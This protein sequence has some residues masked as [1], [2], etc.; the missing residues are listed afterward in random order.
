[1]NISLLLAWVAQLDQKMHGTIHNL[2]SSLYAYK[3]RYMIYL[4][5]LKLLLWSGSK[6]LEILSL[7][8]TVSLK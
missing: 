3:M 1:M 5:I 6:S 4:F 7:K 8:E 2:K